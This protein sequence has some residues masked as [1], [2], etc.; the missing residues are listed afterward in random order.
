VKES[1]TLN[2]IRSFAEIRPYIEPLTFIDTLKQHL[3]I[4]HLN[5]ILKL[6]LDLH[7]RSRQIRLTEKNF[8]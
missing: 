7:K 8:V 2:G 4:L 5:I 6:T 3:F 1:L